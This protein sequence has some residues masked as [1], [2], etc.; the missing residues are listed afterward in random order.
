MRDMLHPGNISIIRGHG[1][2]EMDFG[3]D[4]EEVETTDSLQIIGLI[5]CP[6]CV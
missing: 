1:I 5:I 3:Q 6:T 4:W 2:I